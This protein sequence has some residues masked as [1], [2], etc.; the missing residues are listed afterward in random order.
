MSKVEEIAEMI[1]NL[2]GA[3]LAEFRQW[4]E[5]FDEQAWDRQIAAKAN[6]GELDSLATE[7]DAERAWL[8]AV[9]RRSAEFDAGLVETIPAVEAFAHVRAQLKR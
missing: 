3:E 9:Q 7:A 5:K 6:A 8:D 2:S 1:R 4:Y